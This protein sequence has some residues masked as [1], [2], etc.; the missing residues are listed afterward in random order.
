VQREGVAA[1]DVLLNGIAVPGA[2]DDASEGRKGGG[3]RRAARRTSI[4]EDA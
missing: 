1:L 3:A 4:A 2:L